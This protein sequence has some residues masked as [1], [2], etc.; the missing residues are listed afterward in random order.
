MNAL[1]MDAILKGSKQH[2]QLQ[3]S[4]KLF[5]FKSAAVSSFL[6]E[7]ATIASIALAQKV[8]RHLVGLKQLGA[9]HD[10][11]QSCASYH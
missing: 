10:L 6:A 2:A 4:A 1:Y 5:K 3:V 9:L 11:Q 7:T 8:I